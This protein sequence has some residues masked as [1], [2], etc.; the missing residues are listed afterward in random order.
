VSERRASGARGHND[1]AAALRFHE[2][3][4][5]ALMQAHQRASELERRNVERAIWAFLGFSHPQ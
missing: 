4:S 1:G 3:A 2:L 5:Q